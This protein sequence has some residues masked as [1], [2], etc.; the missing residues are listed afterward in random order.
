MLEFDGAKESV[1]RAL[2]APEAVKPLSSDYLQDVTDFFI[3][4]NS[5]RETTVGAPRGHTLEEKH[6]IVIAI[7]GRGAFS[8]A[9]DECWDDDDKPGRKTVVEPS[10]VMLNEH[11]AMLLA[12]A[13]DEGEDEE[14]AESYTEGNK[15]IIGTQSGVPPNDL[16][17]D[18]LDEIN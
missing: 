8:A 11:L 12:L 3:L 2:S 6:Q 17:S 1:R 9:V 18:Y 5:L 16:V 15:S 7:V 10:P 14:L 4:D 13:E